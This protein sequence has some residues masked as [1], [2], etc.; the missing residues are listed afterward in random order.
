MREEKLTDVRQTFNI[1]S[2]LP[3]GAIS[4]KVSHPLFSGVTC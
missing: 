1:C 4:S 2:D 3:H